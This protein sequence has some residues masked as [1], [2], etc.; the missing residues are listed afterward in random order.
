MLSEGLLYCWGLCYDCLVLYRCNG[1]V[2]GL[3]FCVMFGGV[4][5]EV[6]KLRYC[7]LF[8]MFEYV[9]LCSLVVLRLNLN[10]LC[11]VFIGA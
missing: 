1:L 4:V 5:L 11:Q 8:V 9:Y 7:G 10:V 6:G 2:D 3:L